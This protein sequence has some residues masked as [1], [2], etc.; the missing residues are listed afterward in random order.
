MTS[1]T[2]VAHAMRTVLTEVAEGL[3]RATGFVQRQSKLGGAAFV[4]ALVFAFQANPAATVEELAQGAAIAGVEITPQGIAHRCGAAGAALLQAVLAAAVAHIVRADPVRIPLLARF[5]GVYLQ[6]A[7]T[8]TLPPELAALWPGCGG[9]GSAAA[10]K[11][12]LQWNYLQGDIHH[13]SLHPGRAAD[14]DAPVQQTPLPRGA[15]RIADL[16]YFSLPVL[17]AYQA[18]GVYWLSRYHI[19]SNLYWPDGATLELGDYL[20]QYDADTLELVLELGQQQRLPVR[21]LAQR[22]P[23]AVAQQRR[24][25]LRAQ[26]RQKGTTPSPRALALADWTVLV[27]NVPATQL[28]LAEALV[29]G[30]VRWQMELLFKRW[31]SQAGLGHTRSAKPWTIL[32]EVYAKLLGSLIHHWQLLLAC[33]PFPDRS[34]AKALRVVQQHT[35][36]VAHTLHSLPQLVTAL[37]ALC[38]ALRVG[39]RLNKRA[40]QPTTLQ[41]LLALDPAENLPPALAWAA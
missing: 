20:R 37:T 28:N 4:Q 29:L 19:R 34:L 1:I 18:Q 2:Q 8:L 24:R 40:Q 15:L 26:A 3:G 9:H 13:L 32:C 33:W 7:T 31:K 41:R 27:T 39:C 5:N 11:V 17:A 12:Q 14:R 10:L 36:L 38:R 23:A 30:R 25:R 21:L 16:G 6:D 35:L 22:V